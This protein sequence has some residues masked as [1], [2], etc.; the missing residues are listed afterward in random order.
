MKKDYCPGYFDQST[1]GCVGEGEDDDLSALREIEE[2]IGIKNAPLQKIKVIKCDG[3]ISRVFCNVY[4]LRDFNPDTCPLTLQAD[5]VEE[6]QYWDRNF[7]E[8]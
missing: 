3:E 8:A 1:G 7:I 6:V 2:E 4:V 5:E